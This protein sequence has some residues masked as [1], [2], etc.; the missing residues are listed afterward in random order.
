MSDILRLEM[1]YRLIRSDPNAEEGPFNKDQERDR[2]L[3]SNCPAP[4]EAPKSVAD[5]VPAYVEAQRYYVEF[6]FARN[7]IFVP[8]VDF[9]LK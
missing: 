5:T 7:E 9:F 2:G 8:L 4:G 6:R 3:H 1:A